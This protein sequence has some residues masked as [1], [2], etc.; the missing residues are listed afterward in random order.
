[1]RLLFILIF[2]TLN[3]YAVQWHTLNEAQSIQKQNSK[4]I[5]LYITASHCP[6]CKRMDKNVFED[7]KMSSWLENRFISVKIDMDFDDIPMNL[8][9]KMTPTFYFISKDEKIIKT[10]PG[11]WKIEDFKDLTGKIK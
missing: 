4:I 8:N 7:R 9:P 1:M 5:M 6:Y 3:V 2:I 11:S 10:I